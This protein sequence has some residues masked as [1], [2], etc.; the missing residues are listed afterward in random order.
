MMFIP[1]HII[2]LFR[3]GNRSLCANSRAC[4]TLPTPES[5]LK[6]QIFDSEEYASGEVRKEYAI[7]TQMDNSLTITLLAVNA[8]L[9]LHTR[10]RNIMPSTWTNNW[11]KQYEY[12]LTIQTDAVSFRR[13]VMELRG[14]Y[15]SV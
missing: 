1:L 14:Y 2:H 15:I 8:Y 10:I 3:R 9:S 11:L 6:S 12:G 4:D 7:Y 13:G 5:I